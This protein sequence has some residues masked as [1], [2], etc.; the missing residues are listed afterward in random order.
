M[1]KD[2]IKKIVNDI[3]SDCYFGEDYNVKVS[4]LLS[5]IFDYDNTVY[6]R[7][8]QELLIKYD[9]LMALLKDY[10]LIYHNF[11]GNKG[12]MV[13]FSQKEEIVISTTFISPKNEHLTETDFLGRARYNNK[14]AAYK[15]NF[16]YAPAYAERFSIAAK[17]PVHETE[18]YKQLI[19]KAESKAKLLE[20]LAEKKNNIYIINKSDGEYVLESY[21][22]PAIDSYR[23]I[24]ET[25][26]NDNFKPAYNKLIGFLKGEDPGFVLFTGTPGTGK[27]SLIQHLIGKADELNKRIIILPPSL[28]SILSDP[29]FT[30]FASRHM[31][32][33]ILCIEDAEDILTDRSRQ[34]NPAVKNILN[35]T[36]GI[37]GKVMRIKVLCTVN[38][39]AAID[40]ALLRKGRLKLRYNFEPLNFKKATE[41][42]KVIGIFKEYDSDVTLADIYNEEQVVEFETTTK[43]IGFGRN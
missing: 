38:N 36:D 4:S 9:D 42:S 28:I 12:F 39:E 20:A 11:N 22:V 16:E 14:N 40:K 27:S 37:L 7:E 8:T 35:I 10:K 3:D 31:K 29:D 21:E 33:S 1:K 24:V 15:F 30:Q 43:K 18:F 26:Y 25:H 2:L 17:I 13:L 6:H 23:N 19:E 5:L 41:L 32:E 34:F